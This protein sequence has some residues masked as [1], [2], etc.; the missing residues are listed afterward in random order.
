MST[1][2]LGLPSPQLRNSLPNFGFAVT[3]SNRA[4]AFQRA[5]P[6]FGWSVLK[7]Y[8]RTCSSA[9]QIRQ[10]DELVSK[11]HQSCRAQRPTSIAGHD[12]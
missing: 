9:A 7:R 10:L 2:S 11:F 4:H 12:R 1:L 8:I 3:A 5:T 6:R